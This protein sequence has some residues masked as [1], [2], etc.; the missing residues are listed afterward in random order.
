MGSFD[1]I[2]AFNVLEHLADDAAALRRWSQ[3][4]S[5]NGAIIVLVPNHPWLYS[6]LDSAVAHHRRYSKASL[7]RALT[8][9]GL[10]T[11]DLS[12]GNPLGI[13]G[14]LVNG[15]IL[16]RNTLS[17]GQVGLYKR[18]KPQLAPVE[19]ALAKVTGLSII[20][21][22]RKSAA[23]GRNDADENRGARL[24]HAA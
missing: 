21:V 4:L 20:T 16:R 14:W 11:V 2:V 10:E 22:A 8:A 13:I 6:P 12:Y 1:T 17:S 15:V 18:L 5:P 9:A 19:N 7:Q 24:G 23:A 3:M